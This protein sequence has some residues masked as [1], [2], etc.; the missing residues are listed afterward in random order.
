MS[1]LDPSGRQMSVIDPHGYLSADVRQKVE[2]QLEN[3]RKQYSVE[4]VIVLPSEI[5]DMNEAQWCEQLFSRWKIGKADKDNGLLV[6]ISPGSKAAFIMPGYGMEGVFTDIACSRIYREII[7]PAMKE[8]NVAGAVEGVTQKIVSVVED[9]AVAEELRSTQNENMTGSCQTLDISVFW[10]FIQY[11][12]ALIFL[13][14]LILFLY[15]CR[16][17]RYL[18]SN[19]EKAEFWRSRLTVLAVLGVCSFGTG[20]IFFVLGY[21]VYRSWR[22]RPL[23]CS[24]CG[25]KMKRLPE[26]KDN[27]LLSDSQD[28]EE[29]L[30][31]VDYD[32][33]ECPQC[34]TIERF[35]FKSSQKKYT[36]CPDCH[37]VA[38][39]LES[40]SVV[41]PSTIKTVGEGVKIYSC[42]YC[43]NKL[44]RPYLIPKKEDPT[45]AL[46]AAAVIGASGRNR[47]GF[48]GGFGGGGFGGFGGGS[49]GGGGA[50]GRW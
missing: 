47:G 1:Y 36:E 20:L 2:T 43:H 15:Y 13:I 28:F 5:G 16:K 33:W 37:T 19:Y 12:V 34:G 26:D 25:H 44:R 17:S 9:P 35:P 3:L 14:S 6:M 30:K 11:V 41:R 32:V 46:A 38:M 10:T 4:V 23:S 7:V 49:T 8:N 18:K 24:T 45:A 39:S 31:T 22:M 21:I 40:D 48:G 29:Q 27:E 50:G 42:K